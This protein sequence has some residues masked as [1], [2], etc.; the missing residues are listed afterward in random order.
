MQHKLFDIL[1]LEALDRNVPQFIID[2]IIDD[3]IKTLR[4]QLTKHVMADMST[5]EQTRYQSMSSLD[6]TLVEI[7]KDTLDLINER[8]RFWMDGNTHLD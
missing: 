5:S 6:E 1:V 2:G 8:I 4:L 3:M 7:K